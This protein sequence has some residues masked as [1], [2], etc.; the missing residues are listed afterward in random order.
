MF[1]KSPRWPGELHIAR[2]LF[3]EPVDLEPQSHVHFDTRVHWVCLNDG[4][5]VESD[6]L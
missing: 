4:L 6:A 3:L 2:A 5:P 1:F